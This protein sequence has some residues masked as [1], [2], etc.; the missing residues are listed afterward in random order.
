MEVAEV[1]ALPVP[2]AVVLAAASEPGAEQ[3]PGWPGVASSE[4]GSVAEVPIYSDRNLHLQCARRAGVSSQ[5][6]QD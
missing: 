6:I 5:T 2:V 1:V 4:G 3:A